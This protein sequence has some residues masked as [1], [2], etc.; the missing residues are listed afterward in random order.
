[1]SFY[2]CFS[3]GSGFKSHHKYEH[4][5]VFILGLKIYDL[6]VRI[7]FYNQFPLNFSNICEDTSEL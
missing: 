1:M 6:F 2:L 5:S 7:F 4:P 3:G